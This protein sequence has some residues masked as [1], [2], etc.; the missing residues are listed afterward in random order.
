MASSPDDTAAAARHMAQFGNMVGPPALR[1]H[2]GGIWEVYAI[3]GL[4][5][6]SRRGKS[7]W[8]RSER[9]NWGNRIRFRQRFAKA[10]RFCTHSFHE[11]ACF[12]E[13]T[14]IIGNAER[15]EVVHA[16]D[17]NHYISAGSLLHFY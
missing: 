4:I 9:E 2:D 6:L 1:D 14:L 10:N 3:A 17:L 13:K 12:F 8:A 15:I 16:F 11:R 7:T 5:Q